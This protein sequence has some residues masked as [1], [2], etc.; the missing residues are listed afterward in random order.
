MG[1][2]E[3]I[4][5]DTNDMQRECANHPSTH[6]NYGKKHADAL[7]TR[8]HAELLEQEAMAEADERARASFGMEKFTETAVRRVVEVDPAYL[9]ARR[10]AIDAGHEV[11]VL[12]AALEALNAKTKM[13]TNVT[14]M[15]LAHWQSEPNPSHEV[16]DHHSQEARDQQIK[17]L[18]SAGPRKRGKGKP[19]PVKAK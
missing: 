13:L 16:R 2:K 1:Y 18:N 17:G 8:R 10:E 7:H 6:F 11:N 5:I 3:D 19:N 14:H 9:D 12:A 15:Q 4:S